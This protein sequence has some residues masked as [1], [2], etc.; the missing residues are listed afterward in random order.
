MPNLENIH[1]KFFPKSRTS[2]LG[3][4]LIY[5]AWFIEII[6]ALVSLSIAYALFYGNAASIGVPG[7]ER[8]IV[9]LALIV[10][11]VMELTKIPLVTALYY[12]GRWIPRMIFILLLIFAN[13]STFE[14]MIQAFDVSVYNQLQ[15][16]NVERQKLINTE[17]KIELLREEID[18]DKKNKI[19][20]QL[21]IDR[22]NILQ[23][24]NNL[25]V[26]EKEEINNILNQYN[27]DNTVIQS[28]INNKKD[29]EN[30]RQQLQEL[31]SK[32]EQ[33]IADIK[34][35]FLGFGGG[36]NRGALQDQ[37][38]NYRDEI[39]SLTNSINALENKIERSLKQT[40]NKST[41]II[42]NVKSKYK[43]LLIPVD[44]ELNE[45]NKEIEIRRSELNNIASKT[46]EINNKIVLE[47][48]NLRKQAEVVE[49]KSKGSNI[50]RISLRIKNR[51]TWLGGAGGNYKLSDLTEKDLDEAFF[52]WFGILAFVI[53]VIGSGVAYAGLHLGDERMHEY[54]NK[55]GYGLGG[56]FLRLG[57]ILITIRRYFFTKVKL[58]FKPK[59]VEK[60]VAVEKIVEKIVE[61]PVIQE[62]IIEKEIEVPKQIEKKVFVHVPFPTDDPEVIKKGPMIYNDKDKKK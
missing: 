40:A 3:K 2:S 21:Q 62:K 34:T 60:K 43:T 59:I 55:P 52:Y 58:L 15:K 1:Y 36:A 13:Y 32:A 30:R 31:K 12:A 41:P 54:R 5:G 33:K 37:I 26:R 28:L 23:T 29:K 53:S 47:Q 8:A 19:L 7:P 48:E 44:S 10:V 61:K 22:E 51:P 45:T 56:V 20:N 27:V 16:V 42:D 49:E 14:T 9:S 4:K 18:V 11:A 57:R 39:N 24:K 50:L 25:S 17:R 38:D 6:V 35:G 46:E